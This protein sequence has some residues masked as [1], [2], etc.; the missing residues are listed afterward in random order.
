MTHRSYHLMVLL[1]LCF[2]LMLLS[3]HSVWAQR[4]MVQDGLPQAW[5]LTSP[6]H[7]V[8][9]RNGAGEFFITA[10]GGVRENPVSEEI[11]AKVRFNSEVR[12]IVQ[13]RILAGPNE[14][15]DQRIDAARQGLLR[16]LV[17][18]AH[19]IVRSHT[20]IS[21]LALE[22]SHVALQVLNLS[23]HGASVST[24]M[25]VQVDLD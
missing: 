3:P 24:L 23:F 17:P 19:R 4:V 18:V 11:F 1:L 9:P 21:A 25:S 15:R 7:A 6:V 10:A 13:L 2:S 12:V 16:E 5:L 22:A 20:A 14:T 8:N